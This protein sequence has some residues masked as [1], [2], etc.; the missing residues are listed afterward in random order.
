MKTINETLRIFVD[1]SVEFY[2]KGDQK[3][4]EKN[5]L[6]MSLVKFY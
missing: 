1:A 5:Y 6:K 3:G 2:Q 4:D